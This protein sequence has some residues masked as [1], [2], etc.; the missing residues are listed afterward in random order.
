MAGNNITYQSTVTGK[1][2]KGKDLCKR[3]I[4]VYC[5]HEKQSLKQTGRTTNNIK[6]FDSTGCWSELLALNGCK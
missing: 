6:E 1:G 5:P 4:G 2:N 3:R